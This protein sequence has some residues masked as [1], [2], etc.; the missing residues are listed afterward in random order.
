[1]LA[2]APS[3]LILTNKNICFSG[4]EYKNL[5]MDCCQ[6]EENIAQR[7]VKREETGGNDPEN[8]SPDADKGGKW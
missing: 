1:M 6:L 8:G 5:I 7:G 2:M 4:K 3:T